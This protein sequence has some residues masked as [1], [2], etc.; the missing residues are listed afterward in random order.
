VSL[1]VFSILHGYKFVSFHS[2]TPSAT[3]FSLQEKDKG[4]ML[5]S[6]ACR[7]VRLHQAQSDTIL[8]QSPFAVA[9]PSGAAVPTRPRDGRARPRLGQCCCCLLSFLIHLKNSF[10]NTRH[11][12]PRT[13]FS[14]QQ[15]LT[16]VRHHH[17]AGKMEKMVSLAMPRVLQPRRIGISRLPV[18]AV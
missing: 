14:R 16:P 2:P 12:T 6:R 8:R 5:V 4:A 9:F 3:H 17:P 10:H 18:I 15:A 13:H 7:R 11:T 1:G